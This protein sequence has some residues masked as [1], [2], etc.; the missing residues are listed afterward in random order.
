MSIL[1]TFKSVVGPIYRKIVPYP[2][3]DK[4]AEE[5]RFWVKEYEREGGRFENDWYAKNMLAMAAE[6]DDTF[7]AGMIVADFGCGPRGSL[8]WASSAKERIGIDV[9]AQAYTQRFDMSSHGM[10]YVANTEEEIPLPSDHLDFLFTVNAMD[11]VDSFDRM[12]MELLRILKPGGEFIG[13]FNLHEPP[14]PCEP[15]S[16]DEDTIQSHLLKHLQI[17]SYRT[18]PKGP[19][20]QRYAHFWNHT[21]TLDRGEEGFLWVRAKK[22]R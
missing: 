20:G 11:H 3:P 13:S 5:L 21:R 1:N 12:C 2:T 19:E 15:Q 18:A 16:L 10:R 4:G 6:D 7:L 17:K 9:L 22:P 14:T 8:Q